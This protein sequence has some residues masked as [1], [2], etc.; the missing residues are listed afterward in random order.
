[1]RLALRWGRPQRLGGSRLNNPDDDR[2]HGKGYL[3]ACR[4]GLPPPVNWPCL[5]GGDAAGR[6]TELDFSM[7]RGSSEPC[8]FPCAALASTPISLLAFLLPP[9]PPMGLVRADVGAGHVT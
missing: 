3:A 9:S 7:T 8:A 2:S 4:N 6:E 1:M 5:P